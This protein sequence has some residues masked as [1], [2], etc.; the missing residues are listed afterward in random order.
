MVGT[1]CS[2]DSEGS[3]TEADRGEVAEGRGEDGAESVD[4]GADDRLP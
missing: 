2:I 1:T 4:L 3:L